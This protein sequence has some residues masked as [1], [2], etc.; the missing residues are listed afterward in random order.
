MNSAM[1]NRKKYVVLPTTTTHIYGL[2]RPF[3]FPIDTISVLRSLSISPHRCRGVSHASRPTIHEWKLLQL[4]LLLWQRH[5]PQ[6]I[7]MI[8]NII[9]KIHRHSSFDGCRRQLDLPLL[10]I[11][12]RGSSFWAR[13]NP[14]LCVW[15]IRHLL[16]L[17]A[18]PMV[19]VPPAAASLIPTPLLP[20]LPA[21]S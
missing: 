21:L 10:S 12:H 14:T 19:L 11:L 1:T 17:A 15:C 3:L 13:A 7:V 5:N 20:R 2:A 4:L 8:L 9:I 18:P 16:R 6:M